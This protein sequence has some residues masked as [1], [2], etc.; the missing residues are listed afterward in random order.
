MLKPTN[1]LNRI[2]LV[3]LTASL[4]ACSATTEKQSS[5]SSEVY[6]QLGVRYL[7][8]NRLEIAK[9]NLEHALKIDSHNAQAHDA[10]AFLYEKLNKFD[11]AKEHYQTALD[12]APEDLNIQNNYGR[13]L[14]DR[15]EFEKGMVLLSQA[16]STP[17]NEQQWR[18][19]TNAGRCQLAMK[20][21]QKA[22]DYFRQAL[23]L[24]GSYAP[25]LQE[26]QKICYLRGDLWPAKGFLQRYLSVANHTPQ[27]LWIAIQTERA[28]GNQKQ[29]GD[30]QKLLLET[31][32]VSEEAKL[33]KSALP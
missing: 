5:D 22:E 12:I 33:I 19:L 15:G 20:Q 3:L 30:Y 11:V 29:A 4:L 23:Q 1:I 14:C 13:F 26:M 25:A 17:L 28:L 21:P 16:L 32:P 8:M 18:A 2:P 10:L 24:N 27:T 7:S 9:E 31:F 6:L